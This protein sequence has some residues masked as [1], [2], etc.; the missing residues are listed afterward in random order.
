M[1]TVPLPYPASRLC[2]TLG[3]GAAPLVIDVRRRPAFEEDTA[4]MDT[5]LKDVPV[6]FP[7]L[8]EATRECANDVF[9]LPALA[10]ACEGFSGA[11]IEQAGVAAVYAASARQQSVTDAHLLAALAQTSPLSVVMAERL[12]SLRAWGQERAVQAG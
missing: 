6:T 8:L 7:I 9:D 12:Q 11:E 10:L 5:F 1:D 4:M 2:A 3:S